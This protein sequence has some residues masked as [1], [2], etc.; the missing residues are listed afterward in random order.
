MIQDNAV[1]TVKINA[2]A[3]TDAKLAT[4]SVTTVKVVNDAITYAKIQNVSATDRILG[5]SSAGAGDVEE[6]TCTAAGRA[7][8]D[9]TSAAF[10]RITLGLGN[11]A[12]LSG[13]AD[14]NVVGSANISF[15]KLQ[16]VA[17]NSLLG[18]NT[19]AAATA[20]SLSVAQ[21]KTLLNYG[22]MAAETATNYTRWNANQVGTV[23]IMGGVAAVGTENIVS[24]SV[25]NA[26]PLNPTT[27][28]TSIT[29]QSLA[30]AFEISSSNL[31]PTAATG[32]TWFVAVT[33]GGS[34]WVGVAI[35]TA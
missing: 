11:L 34:D 14:A 33:I 32:G 3:V 10:Q 2:G 6:I 25:T 17:A 35:R 19:A 29:A 24:A 5:R 28:L 7:L 9:D 16:T 27:N 15:S 26:A 8:L 1:T 12:L 22:T 30:G 18:N 31:R 4:D 13:V 23:V 21:V 20:S